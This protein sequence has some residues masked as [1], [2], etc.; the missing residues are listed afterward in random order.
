MGFVRMRVMVR[1][2]LC[3]DVAKSR[4]VAGERD[5]HGGGRDEAGA[6]TNDAGAPRR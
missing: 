4:A 6:A 5:F 2:L 3:A 1:G